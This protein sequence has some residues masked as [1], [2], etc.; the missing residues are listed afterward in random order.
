MMQT[1]SNNT[2]PSDQNCPVNSNEIP[3]THDKHIIALLSTA[4]DAA[5]PPSV[6]FE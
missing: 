2:A 1:T 5:L 6:G 3:P 4:V